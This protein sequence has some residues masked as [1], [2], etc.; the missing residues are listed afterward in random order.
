[1]SRRRRRR[2]FRRLLTFLVIVVLIAGFVYSQQQLLQRQE[3]T[4]TCQGLP[5]AFDGCRITLVADLHGKEFGEDNS[6]LLHAVRA[7]RPAVIAVL[8]DMVDDPAQL[9]MIPAVSRGLAAIA[10]TYY[11]TGNHEWAVKIV[12]KLETVLEECGVT[13]LGNDYRVMERDGTAFVLAGVHD[14][15]GYADQE[16][17]EELYREIAGQR[18]GAYVVLLAHRNTRLEQY[19]SCGYD[20]I[21]CGHGHGGLIRLP[22][23][24]GLV[25]AD[26]SIP[27][28]YEDG[29]YT[30]GDTQ[31]VVSRGLGND[32]YT[33]R[34]F[35]PPQV[36]TVV[37]RAA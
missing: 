12:P 14:P 33:F 4:V 28:E 8:G 7:A 25:N 30:L 31:M 21:L 15:L 29:L 5:E 27:A 22:K 23:V 6:R 13:V 32:P 19:A 18:P 26:H 9:E 34:L 10:P 24:G 17:P 35:N 1:M 20:L 11:V 2:P 36:L 37:L 3:L 16:T